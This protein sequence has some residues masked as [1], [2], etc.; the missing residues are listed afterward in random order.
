MMCDSWRPVVRARLQAALERQRAAARQA[1]VS[2]VEEWSAWY[3]LQRVRARRPV[4]QPE[5]TAQET[6]RVEAS[7]SV[8]PV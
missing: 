5:W 4:P 3:L 2:P 6:V 7:R 8:A 1:P